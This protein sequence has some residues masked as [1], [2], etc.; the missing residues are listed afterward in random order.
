MIRAT[1]LPFFLRRSHDVIERG[2]ITS[3][4]E[5]V[6][7]LLRLEAERLVIQWRL[8][9]KTDHYGSSIR[10][11]REAEPVREVALPLAA[12]AGAVVRHPWYRWWSGPRLVLTA[13]DLGSFEQVAGDAG[14]QLDHPAMLVVRVRPVDRDLAHGFAAE[15]QLALADRVLQLADGGSPGQLSGGSSGDA[16]TFQGS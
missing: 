12:L 9:R 7:G 10:S 5:I 8:L 3:T 2:S 13:S 16:T 15:L 4:A 14:L 11:D 1:A 6:D